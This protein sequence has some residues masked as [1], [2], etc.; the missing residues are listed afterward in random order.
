MLDDIIELHRAGR[1]AEAEAGYRDLL[2]ANPEDAE[3]L[4]LLGILRGQAGDLEEGLRLVQRAIG[5]NPDRDVFQ[6]TLGEMQLHAGRLDE[7]EAAY[8]KAR[9]L[10]P[11]LTSAHGGLGQI[12]LLRGD[13]ETAETHFRIALRANQ[14]DAQSLAGLGNIHF[15]RGELRQAASHLTR[16]AE[17]APNDALIQGSLA[18]VM[19][20]MD[21]HDFAIQAAHNALALKPDYAVARQVLGNA[22]LAK[23]DMQGARVAFE[24]LIGQ[25]EQLGAAHLGLGDIARA[26]QRYDEAI[27]HYGRALQQQPELYPAVIRRADSLGRSGRADQAIAELQAYAERYPEAAYVK[28]TLASMLSQRG[29][30][31]EALPVWREASALLPAN[32]NVQ[33]NL[34]LAL[35]SAGE[36]E[37]ASE[38][39]GRVAGPPRPALALVRA[40]VA[41]SARDAA[42]VLQ[43]LHSLD[44]SQWAERPE[45]VRRRWKL[46]GLAHDALGQWAEAVDDFRRGLWPNAPALPPLPELDDALR[47]L[48]R[49]R[50]V[51][52][53]LEPSHLDPP[54]LLVGLAGS[55]TARLASLL[56]D[57]DQLAVR[58]DRFGPDVDFVS[59]AF[60][61][62][63]LQP[64]G[65]SELALLQRR[66]MEPLERGAR[67]QGAR[68][69][70]WLPY[71]DARVVPALKRALPGVRIVQVQCDPRDALLNWLAFGANAK[72]LMRDP[73]EAA[74]WLKVEMAHQALAA[75]LL[76][77]C[78]VDAD[79]ILADPQGAQ[80]RSLA[81]FLGLERLIPGPLTRAAEKSRRGMPVSFEPGHA[82][83]Y[84]DALAEAFAA[85][86]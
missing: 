34:A 42:L 21:T 84:R 52:A 67:R 75:E 74:R 78:S 83:H 65:P 25:G 64:L 59:S 29:R 11:N 46:S 71:L 30:H 9:E 73:L 79:A 56:G 66:Y 40:R 44:E 36:Y 76:P 45:L 85:L 43:S 22:L 77:S 81:A 16:A 63:L 54:V 53:A 49:E 14:D 82:R 70:D 28:V 58:S 4:H 3:V 41:L 27:E 68:V 5:Q 19:L 51:E 6:H 37:A 39:A 80:G 20:A 18:S 60:D 17:L 23:G 7:S 24:A 57:Q 13:P 15:S 62:G 8:R 26:Q 2:A 55:G 47:D 61:K 12:A 86:A 48:L 38:Q 72:L 69:I 31:A 35:E 33:A 50:A 1:L 10:N 32:M